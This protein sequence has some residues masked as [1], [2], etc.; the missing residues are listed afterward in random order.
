MDM[1]T[2]LTGGLAATALVGAGL[3]CPATAFSA[4]PA[5]YPHDLGFAP[6]ALVATADAVYAAGTDTD[7]VAYVTEVGGT[8]VELESDVYGVQMVLDPAG[9]LRL[10]TTTD[11]GDHLWAVDPDDLEATGP[12]TTPGFDVVALGADTGDVFRVLDVGGGELHLLTGAPGSSNTTLDDNAAANAVAA[13]GPAG[14][15]TWSVVGTEWGETDGVATLWTRR[16]GVSV[17]TAT[18]LGAAGDPD[19]FALDVA[20]DP[21]GDTVYALTF[22]DNDEGP[23]TYGLTV[24]EEGVADAYVP[25]SGMATDIALSPDGGTLYLSSGYEV[26]GLDTAHLAD[27]ADETAGR[28][29]S[30]DSWLTALAVDGAGTVFVGDESGAVHAFGTPA[31]PADL[32]AAPDPMSTTGFSASWGEGKHAWELADDDLAEYAYT[33]R[34]STDEVVASGTTYDQ[35]LFVDDL[36]AGTTYTVEVAVD[37]GLLAGEPTTAQVTT[38]DRFVGAPSGV[39]VQG[40]LT[41][42]SQLS[43]AS[44]G[45]WETGT[46][47]SYEWYGSNGEMGGAIGSGPTLDLKAEHL[48]MTITGVVTGTK[49]G[50]AGTTLSAAATGTVANPPVSN[51]PVSNPPVVTPPVV[52][53][54]TTTTPTLSAMKGAKP[55]IDGKAKVGKTLTA[56]PGAWTKGA[57]LTY[58]WSANGKEIKGA[59]KASLKLT[60]SLKGKRITVEVTGTRAGFTTLTKTSDKT[61]KVKR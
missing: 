2:R 39:A 50:V 54:P 16:E 34:S 57:K 10:L 17:A 42:G 21:A 6:S 41:V 19:S 8:P 49:A 23:Q 27:Y 12:S 56:D 48:G 47:L 24:V 44:T 31:A 51:P 30:V 53:P 13:S 37:D 58:Q 1:T 29:A 52:T 60:K 36:Q 15:R 22:R 35:V 7:G 46:D 3:L 33:V 28:G 55:S 18:V 26:Y 20:A 38:H 45:S 4:D 14:A 40:S 11:D 5:G 43:L 9:P 32:V 25:L 59:D 61:A